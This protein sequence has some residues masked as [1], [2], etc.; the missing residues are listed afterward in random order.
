MQFE[1]SL[2]P[3]RTVV[4]HNIFPSM[5]NPYTSGPNYCGSSIKAILHRE[6]CKCSIFKRSLKACSVD[7]KQHNY[8]QV[9]LPWLS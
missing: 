5:L 6:V 2:L 1:N 4:E 7:G 9:M 3:S 8:Q